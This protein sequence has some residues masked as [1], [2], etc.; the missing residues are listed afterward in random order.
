MI[1]AE[2]TKEIAKQALPAAAAGATAVV[3]GI[4]AGM[5]A[6]CVVASAIQHIP[7][8]G[9]PEEVL[10][11]RVG[12]VL[13]DAFIGGWLGV[14]VLKLAFLAPYGVH[15]IHPAAVGALCT[16]AVQFLRTKLADWGER[17]FSAALDAFSR[18]A[19]GAKND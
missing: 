18:R 6:A 7:K 4:P 13:S 9:A 5:L 2:G 11:L 12:G 8:K 14:A 1:V 3:L 10:L 17:T 15:N 19:G 16:L